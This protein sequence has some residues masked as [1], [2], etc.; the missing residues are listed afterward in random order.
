[1]QIILLAL[2]ASLG[3]SGPLFFMPHMVAVFAFENPVLS[4]DPIIAAFNIDGLSIDQGIGNCLSA[5]L[6]DSAECGP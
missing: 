5:V 2:W 1:M 4:N 6:D 3:P